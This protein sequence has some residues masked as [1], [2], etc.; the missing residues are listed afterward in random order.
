MVLAE[1]IGVMI[2][3]NASSRGGSR[4]SS[5]AIGRIHSTMHEGS[6]DAE[7][8]PRSAHDTLLLPVLTVQS[9]ARDAD[10]QSGTVHLLS[11]VEVGSGRTQC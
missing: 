6:G 4:A 5:I 10:G 3:F 11:I 1:L 2:S 8:S 7:N 9:P